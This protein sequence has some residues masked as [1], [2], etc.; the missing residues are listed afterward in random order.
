MIIII[1]IMIMI[2]KKGMRRTGKGLFD[3]DH[4]PRTGLHEAAASA[5]GP[6]EAPS[7]ADDPGFLEIALVA[8]HD[9]DWRR[10][11]QRRDVL[12]RLVG[13]VAIELLEQADV[14]LLPVLRLHVYHLHEVAQRLECGLVG[15]VV[16]QQKG[17]GIEIR[18][19]P[20]A[21]ILLLAGRVG[22]REEVRQPVDRP[23]HRVGVFYSISSC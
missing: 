13:I 15:D 11:A 9:L 19:S 4:L 22:E 17:I 21:A 2:S 18:R 20:Q 5:P 3:I 23:S 7:G 12:G 6:F 10:H 16:H 14:L 8:G 1:I